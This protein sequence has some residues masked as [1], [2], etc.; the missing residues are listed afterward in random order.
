MTVQNRIE[1]LCRPVIEY[2]C[3]L[4]ILKSKGYELHEEDIVNEINIKLSKI[5]EKCSSDPLLNKEFLS[6]EK[7]LIFFIDYI[8]KEGNFSFSKSWK[9]LS[10]K[11]GELSGDDKFFDILN[12][13]LLDPTAEERIEVLYLLM[14]LGFDGSNK[15]N[16]ANIENLMRT[17]ASKMQ[18]GINVNKDILTPHKAT[19]VKKVKKYNKSKILLIS[20]AA[21]FFILIITLAYNYH[22]FSK[23]IE[24]VS[25]VVENAINNATENFEVYSFD[26]EIEDNGG[27]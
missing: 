7:S 1:D 19:V 21:A 9:N 8:I 3:N 23:T 17:C 15:G 22:Y 16:T 20:Y 13:I 6:I 5:K 25:K 10:K 4:W 26:N 12:S 14:G 2:I 11:Y 18:S 27:N 24:P